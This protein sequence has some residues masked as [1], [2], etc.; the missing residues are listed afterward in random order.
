MANSS[1]AENFLFGL[2]ALQ[3]GAISQDGLLGALRAWIR[4][5]NQGLAELLVA[6]G[7]LDSADCPVIEMLV[8]RHLGRHEG[9]IERSLSSLTAAGSLPRDLAALRDPDIDASAARLHLA[10]ADHDA[11]RTATQGVFRGPTEEGLRFQVLRPYAQGGLGAVFVALDRELNREVALKHILEAHADDPQ[12]RQRFLVEAEVT[13]GL[14]HPGIVPV[15]AL[16]TYADGR[17]YYAMR[18]I[19]G[20]SLKRVIKQFHEDAAL[21]RSAS[22]RSLELRALLRRFVDVCEALH[23]AHSR[24]VLHRDIKPSNIIVGKY[25]ETLVVDWGLAKATGK[26]DPRAEE[27]TLLP[28]GSGGSSETLPGSALGTPP[29]MSP[30]QASG[31]LERLSPQSDVYGLGAT[32]YHVLCGEPPFGGTDPIEVIQAVIRGEFR[33]PRQVKRWVDPGL[34]AVCLKA[35]E[36]RPQDRYGSAKALADDIERWMAD[37]PIVARQDSRVRRGAR[38][39]RRHATFVA[40]AGAL[41]TTAVVALA[42]ISWLVVEQNSGLELAR[43]EVSG[44]REEA[45]FGRTLAAQA[46]DEMLAQVA[47]RD[48]LNVPQAETLRVRLAERA[49]KFYRDLHRRQPDDTDTRFDLARVEE[50][51]ASLFR[52]IGSFDAANREYRAAIQ[53]LKMLLD[54]APNDPRYTERL[55]HTENQAAENLRLQGGDAAEIEGH[56]REAVRLAAAL[57]QGLRNVPR[58]ASLVAR[59]HSD[60]ATSLTTTGRPQAAEPLARTA[61]AAARDYRKSLPPAPDAAAYSSEWVVLPMCLISHAAILLRIDQ[62]ADGDAL[63]SEAIELLRALIQIY[64]QSNDLQFLLGDALFERAGERN[65]D[66]LRRPE[67]LAAFDEAIGL[68]TPLVAQYPLNV[69]NARRL[70]VLR[71][72]RGGARIAAGQL[73]PAR[74]DLNLAL[75]WFA[76]RVRSAGHEI[77]S[78]EQL[79]EIKADLARIAAS[80]GKPADARTLIAEA[81]VLQRKALDL[82]PERPAG[83]ELLA[84]HR[85]LAQELSRR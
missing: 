65:S 4:D 82:S 70:A 76:D 41:L 43:R 85:A 49:V 9:N 83:Q 11:D 24:G 1:A 75:N 17:P 27:Q 47:S 34:E 10:S 37:E 71:A 44:Q 63:L 22:A 73:E 21:A 74:V 42:T 16:G 19:R 59:T 78:L 62:K 29:Y 52:M 12:S 48:L 46:V 14:E 58:V 33:R 36:Q 18:L 32:L 8:A 31:D 80:S 30:E 15:Y 40:G 3:I 72:G 35:M 50:Q 55:A 38:W 13:G 60:Y 68:L 7:Q 79:G 66:P 81:I 69:H 84:R 45:I 51:L 23:Y 64:P 25:G 2:L 77:D 53:N 61:V 57:G 56:Y 54:D 39:V 26:S 67:A 20:D 5:K 28:V 6:N